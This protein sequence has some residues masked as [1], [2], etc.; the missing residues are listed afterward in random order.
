MMTVRHGAIGEMALR[1]MNLTPCAFK[2]FTFLCMS[3]GNKGYCWPSVETIAE[4]VG[5]YARTKVT[6][7]VKDLEE[8]GYI[9][10]KR[11]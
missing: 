5:N 8:E 6:K 9:R 3:A 7:A 1:D 2:T 11:I 10:V 4:G